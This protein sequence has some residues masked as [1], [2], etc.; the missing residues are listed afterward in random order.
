MTVG[1]NIKSKIKGV[2]DSSIQQDEVLDES[3]EPATTIPTVVTD[4]ED[5][6]SIF[7]EKF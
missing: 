2:Q 1:L 3:N 5:T 7:N 4:K 6:K